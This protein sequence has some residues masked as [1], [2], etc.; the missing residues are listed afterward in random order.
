MERAARVREEGPRSLSKLSLGQKR[1]AQPLDDV[2]R[3]RRRYAWTDAESRTL[4]AAALYT[5]TAPPLP[6]PPAHLLNDPAIQ[7]SLA[8]LDGYIKVDT[9]FNVDKLES[10]L[11]DHPNQPFVKSVMS[12]LRNGFW[13]FDEGEWET[14]L[15]TIENYSTEEADLEAIR[16]FRDKEILAGRWSNKLPFTDLLPGMKTSPMFVVW[17]KEKARIITDHSG[18]GINDGIPRAEAKVRY[19]DMHDFGQALREARFAY[20]GRCFVC[21]KSDVASAFLNLPAHPLWQ[22]RQVVGVDGVLHIV[23]RL[24]FG[25][26]A[27]PRCWCAVSGLLC[28]LGVRKL[29]IYSLFIYMDDF[30]GWD[31]ANNLIFFRGML[32]PRRQVQLLLFW[33]AIGCPYEDKK[34]EH[35]EVLKIIGFWVN[36]NEGSLSLS[37]SSITDI[38]DRINNFIATKDQKPP[39]REWQRLGGHINWLLNVLPWGR[40]ALTELYRKT[41]GKSFPSSGIPLNAQVISD[42]SWLA[43]IIPKSIGIRFIDDGIWSDSEADMVIWTDAS[44]KLGMGFTYAGCGFVYQLAPC[45]PNVKIDIFFL[46]LVAILSAIHH[47]ASLPKPPR[48]LLINTDSLDSVSIFNTL[49]ANESLHNA[50][51]LAVAGIIL[52]TGMDLRVR[53][54]PGKLNIRADLLSR[55]LLD[56]YRAKFPADRVRLFSPPRELLPARWRECF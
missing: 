44:L 45:P 26:R 15:K 37:P 21:F 9:P 54:I 46:E 3:F 40:P 42:L 33:E 1:K 18:S 24:V 56:E 52:E 43:S 55:L 50:P 12:G 4:S 25:N 11:H 31:F 5:E 13:P 27:S 49:R 14:E 6:S 41:S 20:P 48:K 39:L 51:L 23:R 29:D 30:Y 22:L 32:R 10:M 19:D 7:A 8:A 16:A 2:P 34:Q 35:G 28:W 17:Q 36:P 53:H 38:V 47:V